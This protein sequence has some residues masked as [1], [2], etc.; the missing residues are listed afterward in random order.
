MSGD[1][2]PEA[3]G[4]PEDQQRRRR[5][6]ESQLT[7]RLRV[8]V[9]RGRVQLVLQLANHCIGGGPGDGGQHERRGRRPERPLGDRR[10]PCL[11]L[12]VSGRNV[13]VR[14]GR[15]LTSRFG[16]TLSCLFPNAPP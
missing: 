13:N 5:R 14:H 7:Q 11:L 16:K 3:V 6:I 8:H 15:G 10:Q 9:Q 1:A 12:R 2:V 4:Q